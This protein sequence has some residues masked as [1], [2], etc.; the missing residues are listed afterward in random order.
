MSAIDTTNTMVIMDV[1]LLVACDASRFFVMP[2]W[3]T[4]SRQPCQM[5]CTKFDTKTKNLEGRRSF[6]FLNLWGASTCNHL[7]A[8]RQQTTNVT[9]VNAFAVTRKGLA[10]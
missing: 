9:Y 4:C 6:E 8:E 2:E 5:G 1:I 3:G 7:D 10:A